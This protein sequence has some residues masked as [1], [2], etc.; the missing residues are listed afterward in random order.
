MPRKPPP[1]G[2]RFGKG[3]KGNP[4]GRPSTK[5][6]REILDQPFKDKV[7][8]KDVTTREA[9]AHRLIET[10]MDPKHPGHLGALTLA[11]AY[12]MGKPVDSVELSGPGGRPI[13]T[14]TIV[15]PRRT[16]GE[17]RKRLA[18][19]DAKREAERGKKPSGGGS[20]ETS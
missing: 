4:G 15:A 17:L 12:D 16:T 20:S 11:C 10:A 5:W 19:L 13:A 18:A 6:F 1:E 7:A 3:Q 9:L 14:D 8:G 2:V